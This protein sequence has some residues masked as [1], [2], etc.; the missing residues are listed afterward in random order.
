M[1]PQ[2]IDYYNEMPS[3]INVIDKMNEELDDLQKKYDALE[4]ENPKL[5]ILFNNIEEFNQKHK[6]MYK[7]IQKTCDFYF[8]DNEYKYMKDYGITP[9]QGAHLFFTIERELYKITENKYFSHINAYEIIK[10]ITRIFRGKKSPHWTK[11]Y[12]SLTKDELKDIFF[13]TIKNYI[14]GD[15]RYKYAVFKCHQC[16]EIDYYV[17]GVNKCVDCCDPDSDEGSVE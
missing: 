5:Q 12:N 16:G 4:K 10:P 6:E 9:R 17:N 13:D 11:I 2:L 8:D 15:T 7:E 1:E 14:E 3:G